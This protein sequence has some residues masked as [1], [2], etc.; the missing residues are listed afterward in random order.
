MIR[1]ITFHLPSRELGN[2]EL[3]NDL[4]RW[5]P[6]QIFAKTGIHTRRIAAENE[7]AVDLAASA[8]EQLFTRQVRSEVDFLILCTQSADYKLPSSSF[9]LQSRAA[10]PK[11]CGC[12]DV[13]LACSG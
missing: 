5:T 13:N 4:G 12:L 11:H 1:D 7:T 6:E 2:Q 3:A 9:L 10:L 8:L